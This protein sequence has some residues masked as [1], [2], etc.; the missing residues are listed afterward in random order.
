MSEPNVVLFSTTRLRQRENLFYWVGPLYTQTWGFYALR[1]S[2]AQ[3][4]SLEA[5]KQVPRIGT[6]R[7]DAKMQYLEKLGFSNLVPA[8]RNLSN[9]RHLVRK[10]IDLWVSSDFNMPYL[11]KQVGVDP[12]D[13]QLALA[14][15]KVENYIAFSRQTSPHIVYLWQR[16]LEEIRKDGT[17]ASA[18]RKY[19]ASDGR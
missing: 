16:V 17:Y 7:K 19:G 5:A 4:S 1:G 6:Y 11:V 15:S 13:L 10:E 8:N 3:A 9:I 18:A 12:D 14:F 2:G